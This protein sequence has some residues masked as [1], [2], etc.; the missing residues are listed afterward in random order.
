MALGA[1]ALTAPLV[2]QDLE[3]MGSAFKDTT[4]RKAWHATVEKTPRGYLIG[5]PDAEAHLIMFTSYSCEGCYDFAFKGDPE[6][7]IALLAPGHLS[8]EIRPR[9]GH[10]VDLPLTLLATCGETRKFKVNHA[11]L[12]RDQKRWRNR[13]N[14]ASQFNRSNWVRG[15]HSA[16][17]RLVRALDF[18]DMMARR[19]GYSRMDLTTCLANRRAIARLRAN[20]AADDEEFDLPT[21]PTGFS[22]PHFVLDGVKLEGVHDWDALY[23]IIEQR[24][25]PSSNSD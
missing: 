8:L 22:R 11:M 10:P 18:D 21:D 13:W 4:S 23:P 2:A 16:R 19:R 6:L 9:F 14:M 15:D 25:R 17:T 24:F 20:A 12:M 3:D 5:N 7:D 1:L